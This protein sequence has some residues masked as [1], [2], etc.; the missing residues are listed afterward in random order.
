MSLKYHF[1]IIISF[2][3]INNIA[4][5]QKLSKEE[6]R[7]LQKELKELQ[8]NPA[9]YKALKETIEER[10]VNLNK[11]D[12][13][14]TQVTTSITDVQN[15]I[16]EKDKRIKELGDEFARIQIENKDT[17]KVVKKQM[18]ADG[19][20]YKVQVPINESSLYEEISEIDGK[21]RP[22]F[23]GDQDSDGKKKYTFGYFKE[24]KDAETFQKYLQMLR[25]K[26]AK[27]EVYTDGV[28]AK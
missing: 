18:N 25:I 12:G 22:V 19:T 6:K 17:Q 21:K 15:Q 26:D 2:L 28:K 20:V 4:F 24:K 11:L 23:S 13:Q 9:K 1:L 14:L 10:K 3:M 5:G 8:K 7:A 16:I 27:I